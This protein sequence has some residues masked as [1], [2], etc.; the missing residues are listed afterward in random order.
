MLIVAIDPGN[1]V[2]A[3]LEWDGTRIHEQAIAPNAEVLEYLRRSSASALFIEKLACMGMI[4]GREILDTA[5]WSGRFAQVWDDLWGSESE[6]FGCNAQF[7]LRTDI[8]KHHKAKNDKEVRAALIEK[9]GAPG[10][11][12]NPG[13]TYGCKSHLWQAFAL[14]TWVT[15]KRGW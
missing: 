3:Y 12:K 9:Y 1:T 6:Y 11:K 5:V 2:S 7:I 4:V 8:K 15:E 14:A 13:L 10:T